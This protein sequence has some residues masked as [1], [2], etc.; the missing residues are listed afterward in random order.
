MNYFG[1]DYAHQQ[2]QKKTVFEC[3]CLYNVLLFLAELFNAALI[4]SPASYVRVQ[5]KY[6]FAWIAN[7]CLQGNIDKKSFVQWEN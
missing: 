1:V 7:D 2:Q 4:F 6:Y 3:V 5:V